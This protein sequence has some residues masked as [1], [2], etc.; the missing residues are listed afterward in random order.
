MGSGNVDAKHGSLAVTV[1]LDKRRRAE[2]V[3]FPHLKD[4]QSP[5]GA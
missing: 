1:D 5:E 2:A 3:E 4:I